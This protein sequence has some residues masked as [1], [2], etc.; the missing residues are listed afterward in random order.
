MGRI[1][2]FPAFPGESVDH[3]RYRSSDRSGI[4]RASRHHDDDAVRALR[5][6][7]RDAKYPGGPSG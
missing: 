6:K 2:R 1:P 5:T 7:S 4:V 3:E